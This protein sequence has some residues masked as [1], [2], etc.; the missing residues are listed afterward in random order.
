MLPVEIISAAGKQELGFDP[1]NVE[2][3][4]AIVVPPSETS[5]PGFAAVVR[6]VNPVQI[7]GLTMPVPT[8]LKNVQL[9]GRPYRQSANPML[10]GLYMPNATTLIVATDDT[11]KKM[12]ANQKNPVEGPLT[13]LLSKTDTTA[14]LMIVSVIEPVRPLLTAQLAEAPLPPQLAGVKQLPELIDAAKFDL[15]LTG[16]KEASLALIAP[17]DQSAEQLQEF[18]ISC[19]TWASRRP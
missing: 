7:E 6:F 5:P 4:T 3:V 14:D 1:L 2:Q 13:R 8:Q 11:L 17:N 19:W 18:S 16:N 9:E 15:N 10:P 12:L